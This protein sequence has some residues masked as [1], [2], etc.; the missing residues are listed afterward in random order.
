MDR[1]LVRVLHKIDKEVQLAFRAIC[2]QVCKAQ[3][4]AFSI[5][6]SIIATLYTKIDK[7]FNQIVRSQVSDFHLLVELENNP[8]RMIL[9]DGEDIPFDSKKKLKRDNKDASTPTRNHR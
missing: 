9:K 5:D 3:I 1:F 4:A 2:K 7:A 6:G 8:T